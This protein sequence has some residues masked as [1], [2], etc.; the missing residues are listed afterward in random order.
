[1]SRAT[2]E[3]AS[4]SPRRSRWATMTAETCIE[5]SSPAIRVNR[6]RHRPYFTSAGSTLTS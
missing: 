4:I 5:S 2:S 6:P 3:M 1:M